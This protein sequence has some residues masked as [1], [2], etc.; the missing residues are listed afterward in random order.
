MKT[1]EK[2]E[3]VIDSYRNIFEEYLSSVVN[4]L[5]DTDSEYK[6]NKSMLIIYRSIQKNLILKSLSR[7]Y[8]IKRQSIDLR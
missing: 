4:K 8:Q 2:M 5:R 7:L 6:N 1:S 3:T